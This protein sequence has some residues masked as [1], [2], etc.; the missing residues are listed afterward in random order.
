MI[1][2]FAA[3]RLVSSVH[4]CSAGLWRLLVWKRGRGDLCGPHNVLYLGFRGYRVGR[5]T[6][7]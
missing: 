3:Q 4:A 2:G 6:K 7:A 1:D 5:Q